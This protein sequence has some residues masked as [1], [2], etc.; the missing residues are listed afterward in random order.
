MKIL[1]AEKNNK[2][3]NFNLTY[4]NTINMQLNDELEI[5]AHEYTCENNF[6][7]VKTIAETYDG[8]LNY[9]SRMTDR[10]L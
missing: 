6:C 10:F 7:E 4:S 5:T 8:F 3:S 2:N 9:Y 1:L